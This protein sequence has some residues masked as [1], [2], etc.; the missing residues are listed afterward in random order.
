MRL[1][2]E[3]AN[4]IIDKT[5]SEIQQDISITGPDAQVIASTDPNLVGTLH[6]LAS[7]ALAKGRMVESS[8]NSGFDLGLPIF[9]A[10]EALGAIV[11]HEQPGLGRDTI[12]VLQALSE[13]VVHFVLVI[14]RLSVEPQRK[15]RFFTDLLTGRLQEKSRMQAEAAFLGIDLSAPRVVVTIDLGEVIQRMITAWQDDSLPDAEHARQLCLLRDDIADRTQRTLEPDMDASIGYVE[16]R[17]L[18]LLPKIDPNGA[19]AD[20]AR[21]ASMVRHLLAVLSTRLHA[22]LTAGIGRYYTGW[23]ELARSFTDARL[24]ADIG[25]RLKGAGAAYT[26]E[27]LGLA[28]FLADRGDKVRQELAE[29]VLHALKGDPEML[30]TLE[31]YFRNN[32]S[33]SLTSRALYVHRHT[34]A[35]RLEKIERLTGLSPHRFED[36]VQLYAAL[37]MHKISGNETSR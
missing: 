26:M 8:G 14:Q 15:S 9:Y 31:C 35:Y 23:L 17:W 21:I 7:E 27:E 32:L 36:A 1:T 29:R 13:M 2:P 28:R 20:R 19:D 34:L 30:D 10:G 12:R 33:P 18:V 16:D 11:L 4:R 24:A 37:L 5:A 22:D 6:P 3:T 25:K